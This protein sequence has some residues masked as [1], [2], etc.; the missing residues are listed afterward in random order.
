[1]TTNIAR[2]QIRYAFSEQKNVHCAAKN[3]I[4]IRISGEC[5]ESCNISYYY[6][7]FGWLL[8]VVV[9]CVRRALLGLY[10]NGII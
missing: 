7:V 9:A 1:M 8:Y 6:S 5:A 3:D 10:F 4:A 2:S